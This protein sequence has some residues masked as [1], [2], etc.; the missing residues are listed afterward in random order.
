[1]HC[2]RIHTTSDSFKKVTLKK[3]DSILQ[4]LWKTVRK[5]LKVT[6]NRGAIPLKGIYLDKI[7]IQKHTCTPNFT[8]ALFTM[9]KKWKQP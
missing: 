2:F 1:M 6:K 9:A 3:S 5:F 7:I 4:P 8:A